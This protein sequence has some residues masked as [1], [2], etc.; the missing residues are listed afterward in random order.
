M[1]D[2]SREDAYNEAVNIMNAIDTLHEIKSHISHINTH[3]Q[4]IKNSLTAIIDREV[5]MLKP[6]M[7]VVEAL[8]ETIKDNPTLNE[9]RMTQTCLQITEAHPREF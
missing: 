2:A 3:D 7:A 5:K 6:R 4:F 1:Q 8:N 9:Y